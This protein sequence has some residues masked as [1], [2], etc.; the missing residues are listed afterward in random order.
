MKTIVYTPR[1]EFLDGAWKYFINETYVAAVSRPKVTCIMALHAKDANYLAET[2]DGLILCGG[3]DIAPYYSNANTNPQD[4]YYEK[5]V[6]AL[7]FYFLDAFVKVKKPVLGIC[8]GLQLLNVYFHGTLQNIAQAKHETTPHM[9]EITPSHDTIFAQLLK[10][11]Q[12]VN[13]Y[14]HQAIDALGTSLRIGA[15]SQDGIVEAI[16]HETLPILGVQWHPEKMEQDFI[17]PYYMDML[18]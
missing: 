16:V 14:H 6:D 1:I 10:E 3:Y 17:L 5:G 4:H 18:L 13:S 15:I 9:H 11:H 12:E 8:R 7:D 2:C